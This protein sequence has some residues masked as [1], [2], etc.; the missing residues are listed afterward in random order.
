MKETF[1]KFKEMCECDK[2]GIKI[3]IASGGMKKRSR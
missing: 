3:I 1:L 2:L